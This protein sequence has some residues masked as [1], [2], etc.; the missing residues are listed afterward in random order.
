MKKPNLFEVTN[1]QNSHLS[2]VQTLSRRCVM[3]AHTI[4][5]TVN[6]CILVLI[7]SYIQSGPKVSLH[8]L[9]LIAQSLS[10]HSK[11]REDKRG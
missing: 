7:S 5:V 2:Q 1:E 9:A 3:R 6:I 8:T 10:A 4:L 11:I